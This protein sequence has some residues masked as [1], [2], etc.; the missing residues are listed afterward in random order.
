[1][2]INNGVG[3]KEEKAACCGSGKFKGE[4]TCG[5]KNKFEL[6]K[7]PDEYLFW[8]SAHPTQKMDQQIAYEMWRGGAHQIG[9]YNMK[10]L[11]QLI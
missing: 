7:N 2:C 10:Q 1:M 6:C 5:L 8:D 4:S 9:P 3:F 11:F